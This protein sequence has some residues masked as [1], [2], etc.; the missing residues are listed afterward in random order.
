MF[1]QLERQAI[2]DQIEAAEADALACSYLITRAELALDPYH[3]AFYEARDY[4]VELLEMRAKGQPVSK[5]QLASAYDVRMY[6][7]VRRYPFLRALKD[8]V[9]W[10]QSIDRHRAELKERLDA[11]GPSVADM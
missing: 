1:D 9:L 6:A 7:G 3:A 5:K 4:I 10:A 11:L 8:A 2:L